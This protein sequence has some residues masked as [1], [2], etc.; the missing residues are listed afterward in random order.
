LKSDLY[1]PFQKQKYKE[2]VEGTFSQYIADHV[3]QGIKEKRYRDCD[4][5]LAGYLLFKMFEAILYRISNRK[6][7]TMKNLNR[8]VDQ[9]M[10]IFFKGIGL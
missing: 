6:K 4:A 9:M 7:V 1:S 5:D 8:D 2:M 10:D 3:M